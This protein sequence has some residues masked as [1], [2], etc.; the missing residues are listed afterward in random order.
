MGLV[1]LARL[2]M[3]LLIINA[4][5]VVFCWVRGSRV[6]T[7]VAAAL[8]TSRLFTAARA[9][10]CLQLESNARAMNGVL[11]KLSPLLLQ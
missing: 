10:A 4:F 6:F 5:A 9:P 2:S 11:A 3:V 8:L 7:V 1:V